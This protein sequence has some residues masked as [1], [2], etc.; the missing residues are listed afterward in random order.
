MGLLRESAVGQIARYI[1][2]N[3]VLLYPEELE[4]DGDDESADPAPF[5]L[6]PIS[7]APDSEVTTTR[8]TLSAIHSVLTRTSTA[9]APGGP[10]EGHLNR[11]PVGLRMISSS[12][13]CVCQEN[14]ANQITDF[15]HV[16]DLLFVLRG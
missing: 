3:K 14:G 2:K 10:A 15:P 13:F 8:T 1:S 4:H 12:F 5:H 9:V 16:W 6:A 11:Y 7:T